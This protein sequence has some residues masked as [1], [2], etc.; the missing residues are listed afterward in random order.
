MDASSQRARNDGRLVAARA[1]PTPAGVLTQWTLQPL[2]IALVVV[3]AVGYV[4]G[5]RRLR[6]PWPAWRTATFGAGLALLLW[7]GCGFLQVYNDS[8]YWVW[9]T[10]TLLLWLVVPILVLSGHPVQLAR[11][12]AA[13]PL[14]E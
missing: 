13:H 9:T 10:Q 1:R 7:T 11:A 3:L 2:V 14:L 5:L 4:R 8:L 12:A 6:R